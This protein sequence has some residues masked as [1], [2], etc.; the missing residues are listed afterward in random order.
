MAAPMPATPP[1]MTPY[2]AI[3]S[4]SPTIRERMPRLVAPSAIRVPIS[5]VRCCT[6]Y[7]TTPYTPSIAISSAARREERRHERRRRARAS[8]SAG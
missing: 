4:P 2:A 1:A 7:E 5:T 8:S 6:E 3:F